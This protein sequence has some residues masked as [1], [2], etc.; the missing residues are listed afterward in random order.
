MT[1]LINETLQ[2]LRHISQSNKCYATVGFDA[3]TDNLAHA[4]KARSTNGQTEYFKTIEEY[5]KFLVDKKGL[6]CTIELDTIMNKYGGNMAN[7]SYALSNLGANVNAVGT[8][9]DGKPED[10]FFGFPKNCTLYPVEKSGSCNALEFDDGKIMLA[11]MSNTDQL[12]YSSLKAKLKDKK[13]AELFGG[14][15]LVAFVNWSEIKNSTEIWGGLFN[16]YIKP[17]GKQ[18]DKKILIDITDVTRHSKCSLKEILKLIENMAEYRRTIMSMNLNET[19]SV[20]KALNYSSDFEDTKGLIKFVFDN[21]NVP[22]VIVHLS[23]YSLAI[24]EDGILHCPS[25]FVKK[26]KISTGGGDNFNAGFI[27]GVLQEWDIMNCML[28]ANS[29]G[30]YYIKHGESPNL[31]QI[32]QY[33]EAKVNEKVLC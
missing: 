14:A 9:G 19:I 33:L 5:G 16:D 32:I 11:N 12:T 15:N 30:S 22:E 6:S 17:C 31:S 3:V 13:L 18:Y 21:L 1:P 20:A 27:F 25:F 26:P 8:F 28:L 10:V 4:V 7:L 2:L 23:S 24:C 29:V